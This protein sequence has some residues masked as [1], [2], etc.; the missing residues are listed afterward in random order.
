MIPLTELPLKDQNSLDL[1]REEL[2]HPEKFNQ[3]SNSSFPDNFQDT[4]FLKE[5]RL[6]QS[7]AVLDSDNFDFS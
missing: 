5:L 6:L 3:L 2:F 4:Q 7:T 1:T